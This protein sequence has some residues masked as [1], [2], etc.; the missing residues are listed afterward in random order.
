MYRKGITYVIN[1][2]DYAPSKL[3]NSLPW[4][5]L[6]RRR[7]LNIF[8][9]FQVIPKHSEFDRFSR[10]ICMNSETCVEVQLYMNVLENFEVVLKFIEVQQRAKR[11]RKASDG[12]GANDFTLNVMLPFKQDSKTDTRT[13]LE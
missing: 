12:I 4:F 1:V 7:L 10:E 6:P 11:S 8:R 3:E 5:S 13:L 9:N 2:H